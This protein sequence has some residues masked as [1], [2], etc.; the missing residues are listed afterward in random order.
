M[1]LTY[2]RSTPLHPKKSTVRPIS[3]AYR[4]QNKKTNP[5]HKDLILYIN[6]HI[7]PF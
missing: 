6:A 4:C 1:S 3:T 2:Q 7:I 5:N